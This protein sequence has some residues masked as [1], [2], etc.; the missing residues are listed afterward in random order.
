[1]INTITLCGNLVDDV[2]IIKRKNDRKKYFGKFIIAVNETY[3]SDDGLQKRTYYYDCYIF[4]Q[5]W[6]DAIEDYLVKGQKVVVNGSLKQNVNK[7]DDKTYYN[8]YIDCFNLELVGNK[9]SDKS[10]DAF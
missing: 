10:N 8:Y 9:K 4:R 1:M 3:T 6:I 2:E 5:S 7:T